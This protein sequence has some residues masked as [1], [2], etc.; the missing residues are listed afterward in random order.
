MSHNVDAKT[1]TAQ[2][3]WHSLFSTLSV[4]VAAAISR[5]GDA[6]AQSSI[7][8][9]VGRAYSRGRLL[10]VHRNLLEEAA[11]PDETEEVSKYLE[12]MHDKGGGL[13]D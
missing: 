11:P 5:M 7:P 8:A 13:R 9:L 4:S 12:K 10:E 2:Y 6:E 3:R 1:L